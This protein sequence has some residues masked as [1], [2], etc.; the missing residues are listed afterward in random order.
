MQ[1]VGEQGGL[2][3]VEVAQSAERTYLLHIPP[4]EPRDHIDIMAAFGHE[5]EG[6]ARFIAPVAA[7]EAV[8]LVLGVDAFELVDAD[9]AADR[10]GVDEFLDLA[11]ARVIAERMADADD[12]WFPRRDSSRAMQSARV[13]AIGF[14][15]SMW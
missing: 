10:A 3:A 1:R 4:D 2:C 5:H 8:A 14:S 11:V 7:D 12:A 13:I 9:D 15:S 6:A